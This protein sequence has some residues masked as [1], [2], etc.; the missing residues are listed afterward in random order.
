MLYW[1]TLCWRD[2]SILLDTD[3]NV[4]VP[5][6]HMTMIYPVMR[7][8]H[9]CRGF[10]NRCLIRPLDVLRAVLR[11]SVLE[12]SRY[13]WTL[14]KLTESTGEKF[15]G[16]NLLVDLMSMKAIG[17]ETYVVESFKRSVF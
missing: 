1:T 11:L 10:A 7:L 14:T 12:I 3:V 9:L 6:P 13:Q 16:V 2:F 8:N 5:L 17:E 15:R 4:T